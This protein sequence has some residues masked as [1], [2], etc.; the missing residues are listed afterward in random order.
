MTG[1]F[2]VPPY[3]RRC[4]NHV[5]YVHYA[6]HH[7][8]FVLFF[9]LVFRLY[10]YS[11]FTRFVY[12]LVCFEEKPSLETSTLKHGFKTVGAITML[13]LCFITQKLKKK[14]FYTNEVLS[15]CPEFR[16]GF[17]LYQLFGGVVLF[18]FLFTKDNLVRFPCDLYS[19]TV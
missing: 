5:T 12:G 10:I 8:F 16:A 9:L 11:R 15:K 18:F 6:Y 19:Y 14:M 13:H 3:S 2:S 7:F 4:L 1:K 17:L